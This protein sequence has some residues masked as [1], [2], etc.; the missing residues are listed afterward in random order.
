MHALSRIDHRTF[1]AGQHVRDLGDRCR[2][3]AKACVETRHVV[4]RL[5]DFLVEDVPR[6]FDQHGTWSA[7]T[8]LSKPATHDLRQEPGDIQRLGVFRD[9]P[10]VQRGIEVWKVVRPAARVT[11]RHDQNR[12]GLAE[13]LGDAAKR[14]LAAGAVLHY[15]HAQ[16]LSRGQPADGIGHMQADS[17]LA[18]D[19]RA[20]IGLGGGLDDGIHRVTDDELDALLLEDLSDR[21]DYFHSFTVQSNGYSPGS[22]TRFSSRPRMPAIA[23]AR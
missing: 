1:R 5:V 15:E 12:H 4:D 2:I 3:G 9:L 20:D 16:R 22:G 14:I 6:H 19:D 11:G 10:I 8:K 17:L 23:I 18:N 21:L 7:I 13:S